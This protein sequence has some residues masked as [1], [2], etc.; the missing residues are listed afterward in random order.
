LHAL[1]VSTVLSAEKVFCDD[2]PLPVLDR[3]RRRTRIARLWCY[4]ADDRPRQAAEPPTPLDPAIRF[5][6]PFADHLADR[7]AAV[8]CGAAGEDSCLALQ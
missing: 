7:V 8:L 2:T 5:L 1:L 4:A 3:T 6:D